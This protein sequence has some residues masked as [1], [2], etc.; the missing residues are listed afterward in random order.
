MTAAERLNC[1]L[2]AAHNRP[3]VR[4]NFSTDEKLAI[5]RKSEER[6]ASVSRVA[7]HYGILPSMLFE[8]RKLS[9]NNELGPMGAPMPAYEQAGA[10]QQ[11]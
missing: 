9:R 4:R 10:Q 1:I 7:R 11:G 8:W 2:V 6:G 5:V 3:R